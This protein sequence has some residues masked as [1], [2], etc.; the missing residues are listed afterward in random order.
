MTARIL[1]GDTLQ[2]YREEELAFLRALALRLPPGCFVRAFRDGK[3]QHLMRIAIDVRITPSMLVAGNL[4]DANNLA[5]EYLDNIK[6]QAYKAWEAFANWQEPRAWSCPKC[7]QPLELAYSA[8][9]R[10]PDKFCKACGW[11]SA[12]GHEKR[13]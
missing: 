7:G 8:T 11:S 13:G 9:R 4:T 5:S 6:R 3:S 2:T 12:S 10:V 1:L